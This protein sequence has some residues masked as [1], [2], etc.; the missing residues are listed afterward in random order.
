MKYYSEMR[1]KG[2]F[3]DGETVPDEAW[4]YRKIYVQALNEVAKARGSKVEAYEYNRP[5]CH[6]P[7]M[8]LFRNAED[9]DR[10][11]DDIMQEIID[12]FSYDN[13]LDACIVV[14]VTT[15]KKLLRRMIETRLGTVVVN[16]EKRK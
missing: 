12:S 11:P 15:D 5:G 9:D 13:D 8:I 10:G 7:C 14:K 3:D 2:G 16:K 4:E 6:N 1:E